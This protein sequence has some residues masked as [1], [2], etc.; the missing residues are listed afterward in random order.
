MNNKINYK[1]LL[2][3]LRDIKFIVPLDDV[4]LLND[5]VRLIDSM[6]IDYGFDKV[7]YAITTFSKSYKQSNITNKYKYLEKSLN[8][9]I[10]T[11]EDNKF[12]LHDDVA[13]SDSSDPLVVKYGDI[14]FSVIAFSQIFEFINNRVPT[15]EEVLDEIKKHIDKTIPL[16]LNIE[17]LSEEDQK[18]IIKYWND[19]NFEEI[20][21]LG[22]KPTDNQPSVLID[23]S[24]RERTYCV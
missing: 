12:E 4:R 8:N 23:N 7:K 20:N 10:A 18:R 3:P 19:Y 13:S 2:K 5:I 24:Q 14:G 11:Y 9:H 6:I 21:Q 22:Y 16:I 15:F 1:Q 17:M